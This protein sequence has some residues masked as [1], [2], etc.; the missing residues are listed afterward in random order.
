MEFWNYPRSPAGVLVTVEIASQRG[1]SAA[2][3]LAGSRITKAQLHA[4]DV[5][6]AAAQEL[7]VLT[8]LVKAL[9]DPVRLG[10]D[11]G[12]E[13]HFAT[14]GIWG[15]ALLSRANGRDALTFAMRFLPLTHAFSHISF[16]EYSD[17]GV[18]TFTEPDL[19][20]DVRDFIVA[21]DLVAAALLIWETLGENPE[22]LQF[23]LKASSPE[24][25]DSPLPPVFGLPINCGAS[26]NRI[27]FS[28][29]YLDQPLPQANPLTAA[30]TERM[31]RQRLSQQKRGLKNGAIANRYRTAYADDP[32]ASLTAF[33]RLSNMSERTLK[34]R[35]QAE[36][37]SFRALSAEGRRTLAES[38]LADDRLGIGEIAEQLG[39]SDLSSFSQA[40]KRWTGV[41]PSVYRM[42]TREV[43][44]GD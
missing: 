8:N 39:F 22:F 35:L 11:V 30:M 15:L 23:D 20:D 16:K 44:S 2:D 41:A 6:I 37:T 7:R 19:P 25:T 28:R 38:L 27:V 17:H 18:L 1:I 43:T 4:P 13:F 9:G 5:E 29:A 10:I 40:F 34:R 32:P 33:A 12:L 21:R 42:R 36:G 31:C 14:F 3:L 26:A 24:P